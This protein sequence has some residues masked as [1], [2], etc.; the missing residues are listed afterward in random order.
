M[1]CQGTCDHCGHGFKF[2]LWNVSFTDQAYAYC[3]KCGCTAILDVNRAPPGT[4]VQFRKII[5]QDAENE[6]RPC[7]C[8]GHFRCNATPRCSGC[9]KELSP[10]KASQWIE[11]SATSTSWR[12]QK[13]WTGPYVI[14]IGDKIT[15]D[16]W[17][18][19]ERSL[20]A[21]TK[22]NFYV[23]VWS[24]IAAMYLFLEAFYCFQSR[25]NYLP[26]RSGAAFL[27]L[28]RALIP[29][30]YTHLVGKICLVLGL[31]LFWFSG[32][33]N[34]RRTRGIH[35]TDWWTNTRK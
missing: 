11:A 9:E 32:L 30:K 12:W 33:T 23:S 27:L 10:E 8:G 24:L 4:K 2:S 19:S 1:S 25:V 17:K 29:E 21:W 22:P 26:S 5:P 34:N 31:L 15:K 13:S 16:N 28:P 20:T 14:C 18:H 6:L 35:R 7:A 3:E